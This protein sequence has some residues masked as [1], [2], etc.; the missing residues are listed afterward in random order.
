MFWEGLMLMH[1]VAGIRKKF[2]GVIFF[3][4][5]IRTKK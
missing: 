4:V 2:N 5:I 1:E 3:F